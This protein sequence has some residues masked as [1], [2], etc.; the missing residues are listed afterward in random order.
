MVLVAKTTIA[1]A[2]SNA[3]NQKIHYLIV[4]IYCAFVGA[5]LKLYYHNKNIYDSVIKTVGRLT[6]GYTR[7]VDV[8]QPG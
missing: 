5:H 1:S 4:I 3:V 2:F 7:N 6:T 8:A